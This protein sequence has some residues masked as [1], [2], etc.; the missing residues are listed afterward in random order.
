MKCANAQGYRVLRLLQSDVYYDTYDWMGELIE[1][2]ENV[3][4]DRPT[5]VLLCWEDEYDALVEDMN[6]K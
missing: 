2:I 3:Q 1:E 4:P 5:N 6:A